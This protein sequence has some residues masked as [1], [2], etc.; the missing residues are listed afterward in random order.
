MLKD[1][2]QIN[3]SPQGDWNCRIGETTYK[4]IDFQINE[5]PHG[6][7]N[8]ST[9]GRFDRGRNS[10][11][12]NE[13]PQGD[14]NATKIKEQSTGLF[15]FKLTNPR[16]GTETC[17]DPFHYYLWKSSFQINE[18]PQGDWNTSGHGGTAG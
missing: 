14:W 10:F 1:A 7:W 4:D 3:E 12:I 5:S 17:L 16:K 8:D 9:A 13:S 18:S 15:A 6:D 2:F 11:Q